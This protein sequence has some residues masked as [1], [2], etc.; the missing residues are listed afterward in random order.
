M[1]DAMQKLLIV[2]DKRM[3][4]LYAVPI[5]LWPLL[6]Q[7]NRFFLFKLNTLTIMTVAYSNIKLFTPIINISNLQI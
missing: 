6:D 4:I 3:I 7:E 2:K 5:S 1:K